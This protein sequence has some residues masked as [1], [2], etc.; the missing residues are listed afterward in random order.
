M[1]LNVREMLKA[2]LSKG[3]SRIVELRMVAAIK[4]V[5]IKELN[6]DLRYGLTRDAFEKFIEKHGRPYNVGD[7]T[8]SAWGQVGEHYGPDVLLKLMDAGLIESQPEEVKLQ[9]M[10]AAERDGWK[11]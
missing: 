9:L 11:Q 8:L 10:E 6:L 3:S 4:G 7:D 2:A 1:P 5:P